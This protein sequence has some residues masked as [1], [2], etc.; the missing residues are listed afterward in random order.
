MGDNQPPGEEVG[1]LP[2]IRQRKEC[3]FSQQPYMQLAGCRCEAWVVERCPLTGSDLHGEAVRQSIAGSFRP[4]L[5]HF[6]GL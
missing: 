2:A 4:L 1:Y 5:C 6:R 3:V